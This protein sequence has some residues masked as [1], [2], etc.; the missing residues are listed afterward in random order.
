MADSASD[1]TLPEDV[2]NDGPIFA[3]LF[4]PNEDCICPFGDV[5]LAVDDGFLPPIRLR[6]SSCIL[7]MASKVFRALFSKK[8]KEGQPDP[9]SSTKEIPIEDSPK[10]MKVL[11]QVLHHQSLDGPLPANEMLDFAVLVDKYDCVEAVRLSSFSLLSECESET[12]QHRKLYL[13][14]SAYLLDQ[15]LLFR[16]Y[17]KDLVLRA[18]FLK[19][20][21]FDNRN[22]DLLPRALMASLHSQQTLARHGLTTRVTGLIQSFS[23]AA[24]E[25]QRS[26]LVPE[27][28]ADLA[29]TG[30]WPLKHEAYTLMGLLERFESVDI[31]AI[32]ATIERQQTAASSRPGC[33]SGSPSGW[34]PRS[35]S[36]NVGAWARASMDSLRIRTVAPSQRTIATA[37]RE[38]KKLCVGVCLDCIKGK[39]KCRVLHSEPW[40]E[41]LSSW[42]H[43]HFDDQD[44]WV[45][46]DEP[47]RPMWWEETW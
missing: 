21:C 4:A 13:I 1:A 2:R 43:G 15:P 10:A 41:D 30:L 29:R 24:Y 39:V 44:S 47:L 35:P 46:D 3:S 23:Q 20:T 32:I 33:Y 22:I 11:C 9:E 28:M 27:F 45:E 6:V 31:P 40:K 8:Y 14:T 18:P 42:G 5:T 16:T 19:P 37:V 17:T 34:A 26:V 36:P 12:P 38:V 7:A 25:A